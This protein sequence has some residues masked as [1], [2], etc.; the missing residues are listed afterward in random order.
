MKKI[1]FNFLLISGHLIFSQSGP[2]DIP[3]IFP[4]SPEA[5]TLGKFGEIPVNMSIGVANQS[6]PI[7]TIQEGNFQLP[8]TLN[9]N[10]TGLLVDEIPGATGLGWSLSAGGIITRQLRGRPDE[11]PNGYIGTNRIG[12][13]K[14]IPYINNQLSSVDR[15]SF[16]ENSALGIWDTQ[17]DKFMISVGNIQASFYFDENKNAV[18]KPYKP[19][20]IEVING[21]FAQ[22]LKVT[23]DNGIQYFFQ[24]TETTKRIPPIGINDL[25]ST[26][27]YGYISGWKLSKILLTDNRVITLNYTGYYHTQRIFS[28][29]YTKSIGPSGCGNNLRNSEA[30]YGISSKILESISF[31]L[32]TVNFVS[33][34]PVTTELNQYLARIDK[35]KVNDYFSK[36]IFNYDLVYDNNNKT[37]KLLTDITINN[38]PSHRY[39]FYYKNS[40]SDNIAFTKQDFW[41]FANVNNTG[42]LVDINDLYS[43][44]QPNFDRSSDGAL[45]KIIYPTKGST[46]FVYEQNTYDPG[47]DGD[48]FDD[49]Y[50]PLNSACTNPN[51]TYRAFANASYPNGDDDAEAKTFT[52]TEVT[53][54]DISITVTKAAVGGSVIAKIAEINTTSGLACADYR[55]VNDCD[56]LTPCYIATLSYGGGFLQP[57]QILTNSFNRKVYL[58]PGTYRVSASVSNAGTSTIGSYVEGSATV[59]INRG[60]TQQ[61][62]ARSRATGGIRIQ[63]IKSCPDN[64][65]DNCITKEYVYENAEGVSEGLL[66]RRRNLTTYVYGTTNVVNGGVQD[67][68]YRSYSSSSNLPLGYYMGSHIIYKQVI[69]KFTSTN[70]NNGSR[71]LIFNRN[72]PAPVIFPF[73]IKDDNAYKNGKLLKEEIAKSDGTLVKETVNHYDYDDDLGFNQRVYSVK[74]RQNLFSSQGP[75]NYVADTTSFNA[76]RN[77]DRLIQTAVTDHYNGSTV[78]TQNLYKYNNPQGHLKEQEIINS[79]NEKVINTYFYPYNF[80]TAIANNLSNLNRIS[81]PIQ[82]KIFEDQSLLNTQNMEYKDWDNNI[83]LPEF[84]KTAK[85]NDTPEPR[86][87]YYDYD[88][89]G[90]PLEVSKTDG[91]HVAYIWG[92]QDRLPIAKIENATYNQITSYVANLKAKSNADNDRTFGNSGKEGILR[93]ALNELRDTLPETQIT[94]YTYDPLVGVTSMTDPKG[95]TMY[96]E[97]DDLNRLKSVKDDEGNLVSENKYAYKN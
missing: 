18:I 42:K 51:E 89:F 39:Q 80:T 15:R 90:N 34:R 85:N 67:C 23:D 84:I 78:F 82:T 47:V 92:Y 79:T 13:N 10:Y 83:L 37:R 36:E 71:K 2:I 5:S 46:E 45:Q 4:A 94:T 61:P 68:V 16:E 7:Y 8:I 95:Y 57:G 30:R 33:T 73:L 81:S 17:P 53:A 54:A 63:T 21:D 59:K 25:V 3:Q 55:E 12:L 29:S 11:E 6:I 93:Q 75:G 32:G 20:K 87:T 56:P 97:Y 65:P 70:G 44:R 96:Y 91:P 76:S 64:N 77:V 31:S 38:D 48:E 62:Q 86:L 26:P 9:Y 74:V 14:V 28:Q 66:F 69:E 52:I 50:D 58:K 27:A 19:Y 22:G 40:P 35:I 72:I 60:N 49:F 41:G 24:S 88:N 43:P 1:I